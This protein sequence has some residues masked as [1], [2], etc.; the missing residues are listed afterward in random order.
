MTDTPEIAAARLA[1]E[2]SRARLMGTA[3]E[4]QER[5]SPKTLAKDAWQGAKEKGADIAEDAVD[6]VKSRPIA[7]TGVVAALAMFLAREPLWELATRSP[8]EFGQAQNRKT[9][10]EPRPKQIKRRQWNDRPET[11]K[12]PETSRR[13]R[14]I[15]AYAG[16]RDSTVGAL[17]EAPLIM[18]AGGIAAGALIA[19]LAA[20]HGAETEAVGPT[21]R[22]VKDS[23]RAAFKAA[24]DTGNEKL[25]E[26]G[27]AAKR[28]RTRSAA[29]SRVSPTLP[30]LRQRRARRRAQELTWRPNAASSSAM[31]KLH[32]VFGGR[33][34]DPRASTSTSAPST[35]SASTTV[36]P[37]PKTHGVAAPSG[38]STMPR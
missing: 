1:V 36:M 14:A 23:A 38:L 26:P 19:A 34:K 13:Q 8:V 18:L 17:S 37:R 27:S 29:C 5:L 16:A 30:A 25:S 7:A 3:H 21:A 24:K 20:A 4:L 2:R 32:L 9:P 31:S 35:S 11:A 15:E 12:S 33:V 28:A 10:Q 22:R 6:A